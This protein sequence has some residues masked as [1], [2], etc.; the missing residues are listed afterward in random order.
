LAKKAGDS[1]RS[2][3]LAEQRAILDRSRLVREDTLCHD[4]MPQ[5]QRKWLQKNRSPEAR[6]WNLL[7]DMDVKHLLHVSARVGGSVVTMVYSR[8]AKR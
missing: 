5:T 4:S 8:S 7:T 3:T 1:K 2:K 6:Y